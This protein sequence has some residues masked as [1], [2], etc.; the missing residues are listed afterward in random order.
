MDDGNLQIRQF[1]QINFACLTGTLKLLI[2][3][4]SK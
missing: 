3:K 4:N 2:T 1:I